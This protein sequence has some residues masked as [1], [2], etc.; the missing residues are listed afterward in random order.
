MLN[1]YFQQGARSEQN[2]VQDLINE[3]LR[4]Y[5]VEIYYLPRKYMTENTVIREVIESKFDDAYPLEAY[6]DNYDGYAENPV[7]LSKFGIEAQ[8]EITLVV[9]RERWETY[10][11][12]LMENESN[13]K[14]T[15]R[16]KEGDIVYFPLGDRLFEIKYVE[17]EKPFYQLQKNYT[18]TLR[19]ELFRYEDEVIDTG[20]AEIDD[21]LTGDN[22]DGTAGVDD[23]ISTILGSTQT[24]TLV[25]TGV[26]ATALT[27][28]VD[29]YIRSIYLTNRGGGYTS[30]PTVGVSS[31]PSGGI[32]GIPTCSM[33]G[34]IQYCNL[35]ISSNQRSVQAVNLVNSGAG[36]TVAPNVTI[37]GG[38]GSGALAVAGIGTTGGVGLVTVSGS[39]SGYVVAPTVTFSTPTHVGAAA[40]AILD[41]PM[42]GGGVSVTSAVISI[43]SSSYLFPGGTTGGV[44]Y[45]KAPTITFSLPTGSGNAAEATATLDDYNLTGG[46]ILSVGITTGGRFYA[47]PPTVHIAPAPY[48]GAAATVGLAGSSIDPGA[49]AFSTTG[50]AYTTAPT[51]AIS[52]SG[53]QIAPL[54]VSVGIATIHSITG[55][56]TAVGFNSTTDPWCVGT[57]ATIG[58]GYTVAPTITFIGLAN[59]IDATATATIDADGQVD[60]ISIGNSGY[61]YPSIPS[62]TIDPPEGIPEEFRALGFTTIR[63]NSIETSGT[64]GIGSTIITGI[65][66]TNIIVGDRIRLANGYDS[67]L[68]NFIPSGTYVSQIGLST[69]YMSSTPTNVGIAT[70]VFE[71]GIDKCGIVT[72]IGVTY[73][74]GG[75]LT[76]P[77]VSISN[78]EGDKNYVDIASGIHTATGISTI[79]SG[80][81]VAGVWISDAGHGYILTPT[82]TLSDPSMDSTGNFVFNEIVTGQTSGT[83]AR[84][85]TWN[86]TT[87]TLEVGTVA[88]TFALGEYILGKSSGAS[89]KLRIVD[90]DPLDDG[91]ADNKTIET[92]ADTILDF[93]EGNPFG[94]P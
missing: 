55:I 50:R 71:F 24:L 94:T 22:A 5:G 65:T 46:T 44:F 52:T 11:Q 79:T 19:C 60:S 12:P 47:E 89:H 1:P 4:M 90:A 81:L 72:G 33:I 57:G 91:F 23:S 21:E 38:K 67:P 39:G 14:L 88:G 64:L 3:Q 80:G 32:T 59:P 20:V 49:I 69:I 40:T 85:K 62:V 43:G 35:N 68:F 10:I 84:V 34:G 7:L 28:I 2:L 37:T 25:G 82:V 78:T 48:S 31:A 51:V 29:G 93:S 73:G 16:P 61:G 70:S 41:T 83:T 92:V 66:T 13:V 77:T 42:V 54:V 56:V 86:S 30:T 18:Y 58:I 8:N 9:S 87:N 17:H 75:Y 74:G 45:K 63:Y 15:S 27:G 26:T 6:I 36:Y 53:T 76:P